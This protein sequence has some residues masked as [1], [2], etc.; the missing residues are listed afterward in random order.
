MRQPF[1][2]SN[3]TR[4]PCRTIISVCQ[5]SGC[6]VIPAGWTF[7]EGPSSEKWSWCFQTEQ[8]RPPCHGLKAVQ[9]PLW[10]ITASRAPVFNHSRAIQALGGFQPLI[11]PS[12]TPDL[13]SGRYSMDPQ[14]ESSLCCWSRILWTFF[15]LFFFSLLHVVIVNWLAFWFAVKLLVLWLERWDAGVCVAKK[16]T[17]MT[18]LRFKL[19]G[20]LQLDTIIYVDFFHCRRR[21]LV[22]A[23]SGHNCLFLRLQTQGTW[24]QFRPFRYLAWIPQ[25]NYRS[26]KGL[27]LEPSCRHVCC[28][29]IFVVLFCFSLAEVA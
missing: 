4:Q 1:P 9:P 22:T 23:F 21:H 13:M 3:Y 10:A 8:G 5:S 20:D 2:T 11:R 17:I 16:V 26:G 7:R 18:N 14:V 27:S 15:L 24:D 29:W 25:L 12:V 6:Y 19:I 28:R